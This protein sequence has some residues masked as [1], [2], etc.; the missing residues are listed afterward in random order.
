MAII[1]LTEYKTYIGKNSNTDDDKLQALVD[2]ANEYILLYCNTSFEST[3]KTGVRVDPYNTYGLL[4][5]APVISV[6]DVKIIRDDGTQEDVASTDYLVDLDEGFID[7]IDYTGA[8]PTK[9]KSLLVDYTYGYVTVPTPIKLAA[10]ELVRH[11]EKREFNKQKD[12]GNGQ[13][14]DYAPSEVIPTQVRSMLDT[15]KV[16]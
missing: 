10:Y 6:E 15:Y 11:Y 12:L 7:L 1:T 2:M 3:A 5:N 16:L 9:A 8:L 13:K 14:L 4:P